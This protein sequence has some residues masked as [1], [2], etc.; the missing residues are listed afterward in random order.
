MNNDIHDVIF[1]IEIKLS[2]LALVSSMGDEYAVKTDL[3]DCAW[4]PSRSGDAGWRY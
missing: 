1:G 2:R 3:F 4:A